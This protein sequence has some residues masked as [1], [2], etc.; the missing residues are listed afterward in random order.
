MLAQRSSYELV[1]NRD[2]NKL[3]IPSLVLRISSPSAEALSPCSVMLGHRV[4][5]FGTCEEKFLDELGLNW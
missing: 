5:Y 4:V 3:I 1:Q 2:T